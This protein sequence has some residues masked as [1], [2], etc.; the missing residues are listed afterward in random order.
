MNNKDKI[1]KI[2]VEF[3]KSGNPLIS[4]LKNIPMDK[5]LVELGYLDSF[6]VV[7]LVSFIEKKFNVEIYDDEITKEKFGSINKM[8]DLISKKQNIG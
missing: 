1:K 8:I 2:L 4:E 3:L 7:E 6:G 5:S